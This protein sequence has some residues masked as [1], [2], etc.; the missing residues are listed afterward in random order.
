[1]IRWALKLCEFNIEW[2]HRSGVQNIVSDVLSRNSVGNMDGSQISCAALRALA[3]NSREQLIRE[4]REDPELGHIYRYLENPDDGSV[5]ATVC[6]GWSQDFKLIDGL[7][8][9]AR[10]KYST[11]L[12]ELRVYIPKSLREA[13]MQEFHYLPLAASAQAITNA[14]FENYISRYGAPIS[15]ISDNGRQFTS[16]VFEH[17]SH[18]LD[19]KHIKTVTY[20]P[21]ANLTER[22][23]RTL[24]QMIACIVEEN[25]DNWDRFLHEFAFALRRLVNETTGNTPA[26]L[27]LG[28][29][30][31]T[32]FSNL[33][34]VTEGAEYVG[35]NIEKLFDEARQNMR[36]QHEI[37][38]KYYNQKR[39]EVNIK[40]NDLVWVQTHFMSDAGR[41][42]VGKFMPKFE[43]PYRVLEVRNNHLI[44]WK[45][46]KRVTVNIDQVRVYH[47]KQSDTISFDSHVETLY[48]G[49]RSSN[50]SSRSHPG[51]SKRS[52]KTS[53]EE[54][55]CRKSNKGIAGLEDL[56][57]KRKV[58]SNGSV[59]RTEEKRSK[60]CRKRYLHGSKIR[61]QKRPTP[62][63]TQGIKRTFPSSVSSRKHKYRRPNNPSQCKPPTEGIRQGASVQYDRDRETR[64]APSEGN[65]AAERRPVRTRQQ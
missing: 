23:N 6:E 7:L 62:I 27:L 40:V 45:K 22:V 42:V 59:E 37:W 16:E 53:S 8:F 25:H 30:I 32:P 65:S 17:L 64:T 38:E 31:I 11:T 13:I 4:Q 63:P 54:S 18:R 50:G 10:E 58:R 9:Y 52:R 34:N 55:K 2:E 19:I 51:K 21:Q 35:G 46:G 29:K 41:T 1:M 20:R 49:Q 24:V 36:K 15:L 12:V 28:R 57:L 14:L 39:R 26:E 44:I 48:E 56:R 43:G 47:P 3:L 61:D 33:I 60:I 5:N